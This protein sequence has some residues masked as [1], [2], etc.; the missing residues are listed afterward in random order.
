MADPCAMISQAGQASAQ[1]NYEPIPDTVQLVLIHDV[2]VEVGVELL[3]RDETVADGR[4]FVLFGQAIGSKF[5]RP[6]TSK[7]PTALM[8]QCTE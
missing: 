7:R 5:Q 8:R 2:V 4:A 1:Q 6:V 3:R